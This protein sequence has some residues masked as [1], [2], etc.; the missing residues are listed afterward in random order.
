MSAATAKRIA[1]TE[2]AGDNKTGGVAKGIKNPKATASSYSPQVEA[3]RRRWGVET[4]AVRS[5]HARKF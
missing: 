3:Q 4:A 5:M 1:S 2:T